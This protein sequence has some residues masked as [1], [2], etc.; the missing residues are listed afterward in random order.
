MLEL[1]AA[2]PRHAARASG[3]QSASPSRRSAGARR[4]AGPAAARMTGMRTLEADGLVLEPLTVAH[5]EAMFALLSDPALYRYIDEA[6]PADVDH[7]RARYARLERRESADGRQ[8][9]LNWVVR[10]PGQ[11]PLGYRAG[12]GAGQR[13]RLGRL[14]AGQ[15]A[16]GPRPRDARDRGH[17]RPPRV[18]AR[19][20]AACW[21]TS[22][23]RTCPRSGCCSASAFAP[24][25]PPRPPGT[26][27]PRASGSSCASGSPVPA[28]PA[29]RRRRDRTAAAGSSG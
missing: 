28:R 14:P 15:R 12:H 1:R 8:R 21:R 17:A 6:P 2:D 25:R 23:P 13:Q 26:S 20:R 10:A 19:R 29:R 11:P 4:R 27:R 7:L 18:G 24:R 5:A 22:R 9:W 3:Q 16:P